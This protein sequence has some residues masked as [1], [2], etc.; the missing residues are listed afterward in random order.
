L[1]STVPPGL[2]PG[3][4][5]QDPCQRSSPQIQTIRRRY[6]GICQESHEGQPTEQPEIIF[7]LKLKCNCQSGDDFS[8][9]ITSDCLSRLEDEEKTNFDEEVVRDVSG[10]MFGGKLLSSPRTVVHISHKG[11][12]PGLRQYVRDTTGP[13]AASLTPLLDKIDDA[14]IPLGNG[15]LP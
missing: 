4:R 14:D 6:A 7:R 15:P 1:D 12:Q 9:S 11:L 3:N 2:V 10:V 13:S 8:Q 5:V